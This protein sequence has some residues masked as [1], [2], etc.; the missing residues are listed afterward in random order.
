MASDNNFNAKAYGK[1]RSRKKKLDITVSDQDLAS[2]TFFTQTTAKGQSEVQDRRLSI[3][4]PKTTNLDS[5]EA[6]ITQHELFQAGPVIQPSPGSTIARPLEE[7]SHNTSCPVTTP[8]DI[9]K[10]STPVP[11]AIYAEHVQPVKGNSSEL[12][13][14]S[15]KTATNIDNSRYIR[16]ALLD[17]IKQGDSKEL[18]QTTDSHTLECKDNMPALRMPSDNADTLRHL[19]GVSLQDIS[20]KREAEKHRKKDKHATTSLK[21]LD[22]ARRPVNVERPQASTRT[23]AEDSPVTNPRMGDE[24]SDRKPQTL[25]QDR[26]PTAPNYN[27]VQDLEADKPVQE[28]PKSRSK[29]ASKADMKEDKLDLDSNA[30]NSGVPSDATKA[31]NMSDRS[32]GKLLNQ[33]QDTAEGGLQDWEGN[34]NMPPA[35]WYER[36]RYNNNNAMFKQ[37]F[38]EWLGSLPADNKKLR[39]SNGVKYTIIPEDVLKDLNNIADGIYMSRPNTTIGVNNASQFGYTDADAIDDIRKYTNR[40][41]STDFEKWDVLDMTDANN[42]SF[43][44]ETTESLITNWLR[45]LDLARAASDEVGYQQFTKS[46]T[47]EDA[48]EADNED[49]LAEPQLNIYLRP[50]TKADI[51][52][53]TR[54]YNWYVENGTG[55]VETQPIGEFEMR[56]RLDTCRQGQLPFLVAGLRNQKNA[57]AVPEVDE[58]ELSR[59]LNLPVTH[60]KRQTLTRVEMLA[61]F[62][63]AQDLTA[64]DYVEHMT[65][66]LEL[67]VDPRYKKMGVGKCLLDKTLQ[68]LDRG[69]RMSTKCSFH[70]DQKLRHLYN[71]GGN[72][73]VH[74]LYFILRKYH[75]P[76]AGVIS[77][78]R[79]KYRK[80]PYAKTKTAEDEYGLWLKAWLERLG[81]EEEGVLKK[82]GAKFGR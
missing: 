68:V 37:A 52:E 65:A 50:V 66:E 69:H 40:I 48:F 36:P 54:I 8:Q 45:H 80:S 82:S 59:Q 9:A 62:C 12:M 32:F 39:F 70:C 72:R 18:K 67:Y 77:L 41:Q 13:Q 35:D 7:I 1:P 46:S 42:V 23:W 53:L 78:E 28:V 38:K 22:L 57:R 10:S 27:S 17:H 3:K 33:K 31:S 30:W 26:T 75:L 4:H 49:E 63:L 51:S 47:I 74:K 43:R 56:D 21:D 61:G 34:W 20:R 71:A 44:N 29:W 5:A 19:V 64:R 76:K 24:Y 73:N 79:K 60:R 16:T 81:F 6:S 14:K 25:E 55:P 58:H 15:R 11:T 2:K